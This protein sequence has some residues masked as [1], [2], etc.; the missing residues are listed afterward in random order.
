MCFTLLI[1]ALG[2]VGQRV[3]VMSTRELFEFVV[4]EQLPD[5]QIDNRIEQVSVH[6]CTNVHD[7][8]THVFVRPI[9]GTSSARTRVA[10]SVSMRSMFAV[11]VCAFAAVC[12]VL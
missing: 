9:A 2:S 6:L 7:V 5:D 4:D 10:A 12:C 1:G 3:A 11:D 8:R